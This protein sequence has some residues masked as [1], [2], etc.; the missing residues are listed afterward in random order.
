MNDETMQISAKIT[1]SSIDSWAAKVPAL[2]LPPGDD[3][4]A[5]KVLSCPA[6]VARQQGRRQSLLSEA[7]TLTA[8]PATKNQHLEL[9]AKA[10]DLPG[11]PLQPKDNRAAA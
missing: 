3:Q 11:R 5:A 10:A 4:R 1:S 7:S 6:T 9:T 2:R 8:S